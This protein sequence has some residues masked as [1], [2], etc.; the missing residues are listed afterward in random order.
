MP[1]ASRAGYE[2]HC[3]GYRGREP[4]EGNI[5]RLARYL[6]GRKVHFVGHSTGG[7]LIYDFLQQ[8]ASLACGRVESLPS[9]RCADP[10]PPSALSPSPCPRAYLRTCITPW[11]GDD[12]AKPVVILCESRRTN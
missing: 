6:D 11:E 1:P 5:E 9:G 2:T 4:L 12:S 10:L 7:V 8:H 3:F